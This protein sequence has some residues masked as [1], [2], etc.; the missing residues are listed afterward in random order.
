MPRV[1]RVFSAL[2]HKSMMDVVESNQNLDFLVQL[3][4]AQW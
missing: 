4:G 3:Q 1:A 2:I